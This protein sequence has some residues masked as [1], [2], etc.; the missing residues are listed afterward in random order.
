MT[1][2]VRSQTS[3]KHYFVELDDSNQATECGCPDRAYRHHTCKHMREVTEQVARAL[4]F[5]ALRQQ[6][7]YRSE[8]QRAIRR[9]RFLNYE[10]SIGVL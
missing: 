7:D 9:E 4:A 8:T 3:N 10:L 6:Y 1:L 2:T 5:A